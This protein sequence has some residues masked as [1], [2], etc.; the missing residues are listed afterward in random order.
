MAMEFW[1]VEVKSGKS[2]KVKSGGSFGLHLSQASL[3]EFQKEKGNESVCLYVT[4]GDQ[5][6][7]LGTLSPQKFPQLSFDLV[8]N[9]DFELSHNW[10]S[11]SVYF[12]GYRGPNGSDNSSEDEDESE[13]DLPI[14]A[15]N[16]KPK[17][18][19]KQTKPIA[20]STST[21][22]PDSTVTKQKM[23]IVEASKDVKF[24]EENDD[25]IDEEDDSLSDDQA[26]SDDV[27]ED[28]DD[29]EDKHDDGSDEEEDKSDD[30]DKEMQKK[31][32]VF[33][34]AN[35]IFGFSKCWPGVC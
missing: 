33:V 22:K 30:E 32:M 19:A 7:V 11:G 12:L 26:M 29:D 31:V 17:S 24:D 6:F 28:D 5:K 14:T 27:D 35:I 1:G 4:I 15:H 20:E 3:G 18:E 9:E 2:M 16:G 21:L 23:K 34:A 13:E 8:F 10:K 25:S